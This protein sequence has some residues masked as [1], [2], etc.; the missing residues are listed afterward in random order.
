MNKNTI[1]INV[2]DDYWDDGYVPEGELQ[3]TFAYV[4]DYDISLEEKGKILLYLMNFIYENIELQGTEMSIFIE[5][6]RKKYAK[7]IGT[8]NEFMLKKRYKLQ[9]KNLTHKQREALVKILQE[10][11]LMFEGKEVVIYSES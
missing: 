6:D 4:E 3:E 2:W 8:E 11:N 1:P 5:D 9:F 10:R 7:L